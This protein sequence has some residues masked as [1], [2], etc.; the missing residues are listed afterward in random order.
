[1]LEELARSERDQSL[2]E[3]LMIG[4]SA[5]P[6]GP[7]SEHRSPIWSS[8][9]RSTGAKRPGRVRKEADCL[10]SIDYAPLLALV[11]A[12]RSFWQPERSRPVPSSTRLSGHGGTSADST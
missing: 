11:A 1:M 3:L 7:L 6:P 4:N 5:T 9:G 2:D 10:E 12:P 8:S